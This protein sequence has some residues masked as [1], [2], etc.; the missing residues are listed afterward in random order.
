MA[1]R[2]KRRIRLEES[3]SAIR[4]RLAALP[5]KLHGACGMAL[6]LIRRIPRI[7][8][9]KVKL[10]LGSLALA[11]AILLLTY[12]SLASSARRVATEQAQKR[13]AEILSYFSGI[14]AEAVAAGDLMQVHLLARALLDNGVQALTVA[15]K[16]GG[17]LYAS[18]PEATGA[19]LR[20][21]ADTKP[22]A[23]GILGTVTADGKTFLHA[24]TPI[25]FGSSPVGT[26]H[27]WLNQT[28]LEDEI[29]KANAF[30]SPIF[31]TGF[32]LMLA[33]GVVGLRIPFRA[34][35][36]LSIAAERIGR[37]DLSERIPIN[38]RDEVAAFCQAFNRMVDGLSSAQDEILCRHLETI[39][40]MISAVEA[41]D[42]YTQGHCVRV[43]GYASKI[44]EGF[45]DLPAEEKHRIE[46][47][48]LLHDIG[49]IGIPDDVLFKE[50]RLS[51]KEVEI[52][53]THVLIG[54]R[55]VLHL[56]SMKEIA[57]WIRHHHER[58]DGLGYPDGL[59]GPSIPFAS[60]V[61]GVADALDAM[62]T[63][64]PYRKGLTRGK[65]TR[66]LAAGRGAQ[67]DPDVV[68][69]AIA[70]LLSEERERERLVAYA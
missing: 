46:T 43:Q 47:A 57:R 49:K 21:P 8:S 55:I 45:E 17:V 41:K 40:A 15:D 23:G 20:S 36:R 10:T 28:D 70:Y 6:R 61:I 22:F 32:I 4:A 69:R 7:E 27:L 18:R 1:L 37:G 63:D 3:L 64:R 35:K 66:A 34:M 19:G 38:G 59:R 30:V 67:F 31:P 5:E 56:D 42:S 39:R 24:A 44:L 48:A 33:L 65:A 29:Q 13:V 51:R 58:W 12:A 16:E 14:F 62:L 60:R 26:I 50:H 11:T 52:I 54:E 25:R 2:L 53:R 9:L 68:D